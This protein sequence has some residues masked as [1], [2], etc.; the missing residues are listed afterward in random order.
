[1]DITPCKI[2]TKWC[3]KQ[4]QPTWKDGLHIPRDHQVNDGVN[5]HHPYTTGQA[6]VILGNGAGADVGPLQS[7]TLLLVPGD[8]AAAE[9]KS[10]SGREALKHSNQ[11][12][13]L[14]DINQLYHS[15]HLSSQELD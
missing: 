15:Y 9:A 5:Q 13:G 7:N 11:Q 12:Y 10:N 1:M 2:S 14:Q 6:E 4:N 8:V 3:N